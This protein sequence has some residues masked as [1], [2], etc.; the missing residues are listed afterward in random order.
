MTRLGVFRLLCAV[1]ALVVAVA[2]VIQ[3]ALILSGGRDANSGAATSQVGIGVSFVRL[4][5]FFT[6]D[7]NIVVMIV[8]A[9]LAVSPMRS[10]PRW[11]VARL[12][13]LL[14]ITI[15]GIVFDVVLSKQVHLTG[16]ALV[17]TILFH[18]VSPWLTVL[19]WLVFGPRPGF[20]WRTMPGAFVLP[21]LWLVYTFVHGAITHWYPY[22]FLDVTKIGLGAAVLNAVLVLAIGVVLSVV[23]ILLSKRMLA[24]LK[25]SA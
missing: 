24:V 14:A 2:L 15:T 17:A 3:I 7:S 1:S 10:S 4:L 5:S 16:A 21:V 13:A 11:Q 12:N 9:A 6:I 8:A 22:P 23:F 20:T 18:Y 19:V 25:A